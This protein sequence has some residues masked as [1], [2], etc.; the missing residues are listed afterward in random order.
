MAATNQATSWVVY[1]MNI[2]G[3]P[4]GM[5]AVCEQWEWDALQLTQHGPHTLIQ[6]GITNEGE[7]EKLARF[8]PVDP[9]KR[10]Y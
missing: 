6:A 3:K 9:N 2:P 1:L 4:E 5:R 8:G 7:A 10:E